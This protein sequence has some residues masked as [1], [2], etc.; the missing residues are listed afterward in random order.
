MTVSAFCIIISL[1]HSYN[2]IRRKPQNM[3]T[4]TRRATR[5]HSQVAPQVTTD[6]GHDYNELA[7]KFG[8]TVLDITVKRKTYHAIVFSKASCYKRML[9]AYSKMAAAGKVGTA[10]ERAEYANNYVLTT[11]EYSYA[12]KN[13][14]IDGLITRKA[15]DNNFNSPTLLN[16]YVGYYYDQEKQEW[17][18]VPGTYVYDENGNLVRFRSEEWFYFR[19]KK[20]NTPKLFR[21]IMMYVLHGS[22]LK[23]IYAA[24][25]VNPNQLY[26]GL[27]RFGAFGKIGNKQVLKAKDILRHVN[28]INAVRQSKGWSVRTT[29][30]GKKMHTALLQNAFN[31]MCVALTGSVAAGQAVVAQRA[32]I[33]NRSAN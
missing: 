16:H 29:Y 5:A 9:K 22:T 2:I 33:A 20:I 12:C 26:K 31:H 15:K 13:C 14:T 4:T 17:R 7:S 3:S 10:G 25:D 6:G 1:K 18:K 28:V 11:Y 27:E 19:T 24:T 23:E 32:T 30:K 8:G 21:A